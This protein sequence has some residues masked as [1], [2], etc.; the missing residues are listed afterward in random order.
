MKLTKKKTIEYHREMW[1]WLAETGEKYKHHWPGFEKMGWTTS[2]CFLC[3]YAETH[4]KH[5]CNQ[6][7]ILIWPPD[8]QGCDEG[9][10]PYSHWDRAK[11]KRTRKKYAKIISEL[12]ERK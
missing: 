11:T 3:E 12:P 4:T 5:Y 6:T 10:D 8:D 2:Y 1:N 9:K 7:C